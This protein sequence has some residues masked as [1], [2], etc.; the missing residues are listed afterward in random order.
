MGEMEG[1]GKRS[2]MEGG[3][4]TGRGRNYIYGEWSIPILLLQCVAAQSLSR[5]ADDVMARL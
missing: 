3:K 5:A 1:A 4:E 2:K